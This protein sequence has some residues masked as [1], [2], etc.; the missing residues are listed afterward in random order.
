MGLVL[1]A[2][3]IAGAQYCPNSIGFFMDEAATVNCTSTAAPY[4]NLTVY[5]VARDI[6]TPTVGLSGWECAVVTDP[7]TLPAGITVTLRYGALNVL[8][9]PQFNVGLPA[10]GGTG[11]GS[12]FV[13][14]S[15]STFYLGGP[16]KFG[17]GPT[18]PSS[19]PPD[20]QGDGHP[21]AT[22]GYAQGDN[23]GL[24]HRLF[25]ISSVPS[26]SSAAYWTC[27]VNA[28]GEPCPGAPA[29]DCGGSPPPTVAIDDIQVYA[30]NGVPASPYGAAYVICTGTVTCASG[31]FGPGTFYL[32]DATGGIQVQYPGT[33]FPVGRRAT[34]AGF[35]LAADGEIHVAGASNTVLGTDPAPIP[36]D[37][38]LG[39]ASDYEVVGELVK[40][41][42]VAG[43]LT[44]SGFSLDD[45]A[46]TFPVR[47]GAGTG[48][49][50]T[51]VTVG[52]RY[53]VTGIL[54]HAG[55]SLA[56]W[57]RSAA[58]LFDVP[59]Q[60]A[61][62]IDVTASIGEL[63]DELLRL[64]ASMVATD[65]Y[66]AHLDL[67]NPPA[68]PSAY[69]DAYFRHPEWASP[70]GAEFSRDIRALY[71]LNVEK[72]IWPLAVETDQIGTVTLQ[73][74]PSFGVDWGS[75]LVV[76]D[77]A[78]G[79]V[80]FLLP[81]LV[82]SYESTGTGRRDLLVQVGRY[83]EVPD[84]E[85]P[86]RSIA[87]GWSMLGM[88]LVPAAG[89]ST[90]DDVIL[91]DLAALAWV[92]DFH[93]VSGYA[94]MTGSDPL[95]IGRG[96]WLASTAGFDWS[97]EGSQ[98]IG[99][100]T[101]P[102]ANGWSL[103]GYPLWFTLP[104]DNVRVLQGGQEYTY[105]EAV[106]GNLVSGNVYGW[107]TAL[108]SYTTN[109][110]LHAWQGYWVAAYADDVTLRFN[111]RYLDAGKRSL[112][113][114]DLPGEVPTPDD[115]RVRIALDSLFGDAWSVIGCAEGAGDG[116][117]AACD[118]PVAPAAPVGPS[119]SLS[120]QHPEWQLAVG[121]GFVSD[122][123]SSK[124]N[125]QVWRALVQLPEPGQVVLSWGDA[126]WPKDLDLNLYLPSQNR[127]VVRSMRA[128]ASVGLDV[129]AEGLVVE[130][131]TPDHVT[132]V[133]PDAVAAI[134]LHCVPNP[135]NPSTEVRFDLPRAARQ[136]QFARATRRL[137]RRSR[138]CPDFPP[139][140]PAKLSF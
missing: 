4:S 36:R 121:S 107:D 94:L 133:P 134:G 13:L 39:A 98:D 77:L 111:Y 82:Y 57:P 27:Y 119:P 52:H 31:T 32:Q 66:D 9:Y 93:G 83:Y 116:F 92:F 56:L 48:L 95:L 42:G 75:D 64:G 19:F 87:A 30:P 35:V 8:A 59:S 99:D 20:F 29:W 103:L 129:P 3:A 138:L 132:G 43:A 79:E 127:V 123:R 70:F 139:G 135:F 17:V 14:A 136:G 41:I 5:L 2:P 109:V 131:R 130:F 55:G 37:V 11:P 62:T 90:V 50:V 115:W 34:I 38:A 60:F 61:F 78:T 86:S 40:L 22:P 49:D 125:S 126:A 45:G 105:A 137:R 97:M 88:P 108:A 112:A 85:P 24:M 91:T 54:R 124:S 84:I 1:L 47:F 46:Q 18:T 106:A 71:D 96:V 118:L 73:F 26:G 67:P 69:I 33:S 76:E 100:V 68:P 58:D 25:P 80:A 101:V 7:A 21:E 104:L 51:D 10:I 114:V 110:D 72:R 23:P 6:G 15:L 113:K 89:S 65:G 102:L 140:S 53:E 74:A 128:Q 81:D 12:S 16:I 117:D 120:I 122:L 28:V 44:T 63:S